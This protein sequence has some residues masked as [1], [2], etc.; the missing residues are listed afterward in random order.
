VTAKKYLEQ[1]ELIQW[2]IAQKTRELDRLKR[3]NRDD[4]KEKITVLE[5]EISADIAS[6]Y[7]RRNEIVNRICELN[8]KLFIDILYRRYVMG[9]KNFFEIAYDM[10][11]AYKYIINMHGVA[12]KLFEEIHHDIL[13]GIQVE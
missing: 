2:K 3:L 12:I 13:D 7:E 11:Y 1:I 10:N 5:E 6:L 9:E 4:L 8:N